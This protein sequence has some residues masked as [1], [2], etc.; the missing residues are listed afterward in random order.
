MKFSI[1]QVDNQS[2]NIVDGVWIQDHC[3]TLETATE[4]ARGTELANGKRITV[5]VVRSLG[6]S[7]PNYSHRTGMVR[8]DI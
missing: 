2:G 4:C 3:G 5:A 1:V 6:G 7:C 8:L